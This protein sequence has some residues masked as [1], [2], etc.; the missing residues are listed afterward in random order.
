VPH[1]LRAVDE[2]ATAQLI[3]NAEHALERWAGELDA[4]SHGRWAE[5]GGQR[6]E[7]GAEA[8]GQ[9]SEIGGWRSEETGRRVAVGL[10]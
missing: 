3:V 5:A 8:R 6:P 10:F 4:G 7:A 2:R 9:M 1:Q